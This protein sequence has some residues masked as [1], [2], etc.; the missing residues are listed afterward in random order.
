[1]PATGDVITSVSVYVSPLVNA[2]LSRPNEESE[3]CWIPRTVLRLTG[4]PP[5]A[6]RSASGSRAAR[7]PDLVLVDPLSRAARQR[8]P[9]AP[10]TTRRCVFG[11]AVSSSTG[12]QSGSRR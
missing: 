8:G 7:H 3:L 4:S 12:P 10:H 11:P 2:R 6:S 1:V 9:P 5:L